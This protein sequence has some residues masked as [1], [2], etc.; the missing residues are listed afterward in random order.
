MPSFLSVATGV[1]VLVEFL[2]DDVA[3]PVA[4]VSMT[5]CPWT[6]AAIRAGSLVPGD[7]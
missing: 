2:P 6:S 5:N 7:L 1:G 4:A 3:D